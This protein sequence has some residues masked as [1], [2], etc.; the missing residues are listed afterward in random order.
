MM[1]RPF[2]AVV[3]ISSILSVSAGAMNLLTNPSFENG[4]GAVTFS[5]SA[6]FGGASALELTSI[7][8]EIP[9]WQWEQNGGGAAWLEESGDMFG[10]D[11]THLLYLDSNQSVQWDDGVEVVADGM[12]ELDYRFAAWARGQDNSAAGSGDAT[13]LLEYNYRD[14]G[15]DIHF[16]TYTGPGDIVAPANGSSPPGSLIW[17]NGSWFFTIPSDY[18]SAFNFQIGT[19]GGMLID[20]L[21]IAAVPEPGAAGL[22]GLALVMFVLRRTLRG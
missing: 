11:G 2:I 16:G 21:A 6:E 9:G 3:G 5:A 4:A 14:G 7:S 19:T 8:T 20:E 15:G 17:E 1:N 18:G 13:A 10:T 22:F 12:Y